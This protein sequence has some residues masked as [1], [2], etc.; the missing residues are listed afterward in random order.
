MAKKMLQIFK[1]K[2][3]NK[4]NEYTRY[5]G[6]TPFDTKTLSLLCDHKSE[7]NASNV[8]PTDVMEESY[9]DIIDAKD[10]ML[11][12]G[13]KQIKL[14]S[15]TSQGELIKVCSTKDPT[16]K[17]IIKKIP[18]ATFSQKIIIR[19]IVSDTYGNKPFCVEQNIIKEA[20]L[21]HHGSVSNKRCHQSKY[22]CK[23]IEFF[24]DENYYYLVMEH[25]GKMTLQNWIQIAFEYM[26]KEQLNTIHYRK[27]IKY[28]FW[29][30]VLII[31]WLHNE[32][33]ICHLAV[34]A[35]NIF[36]SNC[37]FKIHSDGSVTVPTNIHIKL[38]NWN[39]AEIFQNA[40]DEFLHAKNIDMFSLGNLLYLLAFGKQPNKYAIHFNELESHIRSNNLSKFTTISMFKLICGMLTYSE[41]NR[42]NISDVIQSQWFNSY[43]NKYK[44][45]I[46]KKCLSNI[47]DLDDEFPYY[48]T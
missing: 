31:H 44:M 10:T 6:F 14:L 15:T 7:S 18:K 17:F 28:I 37:K 1:H 46:S 8:T 26:R 4:S 12:Q 42:Y 27:I 13:Y 11:E 22:I 32:H 24:K 30:I 40:N 43:W 35:A 19:S 47:V 2:K 23:Y 9:P 39:C 25:Y 3:D 48:R 16:Q 21:L 38:C 41:R 34:N 33:K 36:V 45:T 20:L 5:H 29:Q